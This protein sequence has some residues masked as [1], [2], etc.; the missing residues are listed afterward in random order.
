MDFLLHQWSSKFQ[1]CVPDGFVGH[2]CRLRHPIHD[3]SCVFR[4]DRLA[5]FIFS[6]ILE[7]FQG[8][9][10]TEIKI[11]VGDN[12]GAPNLNLAENGNPLSCHTTVLTAILFMSGIPHWL[13]MLGMYLWLAIFFLQPHKEERFL[14]PI[15][16]LFCL[17]AAITVDSLQVKIF[18]LFIYLSSTC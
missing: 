11:P 8:V 16:P 14:F 2:L 4:W 3:R 17:N 9:S 10:I 1:H 5:V 7:G 18:N 12:Q 6:S 13:S 15:Y